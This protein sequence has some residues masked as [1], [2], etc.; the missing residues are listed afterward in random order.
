MS[1]G[2]ECADSVGKYKLER[3]QLFD[4]VCELE[5]TLELKIEAEK[6]SEQEIALLQEKV[7]ALE[8][9]N[10]KLRVINDTYR[11]YSGK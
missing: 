7:E 5:D 11:V 4:T 9:E 8:K 10:L 6:E 3:D 2:A 1:Q